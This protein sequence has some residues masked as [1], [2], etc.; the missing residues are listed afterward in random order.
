MRVRPILIVVGNNGGVGLVEVRQRALFPSH[1]AVGLGGDRPAAARE[2]LVLEVLLEDHAG[3]AA[4]DL[5]ARLDRVRAGDVLKRIARHGADGRAVDQHGGNGVARH[6]S[7]REGLALAFLD[8]GAADRVDAAALT[9]SRGDLGVALDVGLDACGLHLDIVDRGD[10]GI[11]LSGRSGVVPAQQEV[12]HAK[13]G[14]KLHKGAV[15]NDIA[16]HG[17]AQRV[18]CIPDGRPCAAAVGGGLDREGEFAALHAVVRIGVVEF[19]VCLLRAAQIDRRGDQALVLLGLACADVGRLGLV[20]VIVAIASPRFAAAGALPALG[21]ELFGLEVLLKEHF[22]RLGDQLEARLDIIV[23]IDV[24][25]RVGRFLADAAAVDAIGQEVEAALRR[26]REAHAAVGR[27]GLHAA[28]RDAAALRGDGVDRVGRFALSGLEG[29][30][31]RMVDADHFKGIVA[32]RAEIDAVDHQR[33]DLVAGIRRDREGLGGALAHERS[34]GRRDRAVLGGRGLHGDIILCAI[35]IDLHAAEA[36]GRATLMRG[37]DEGKADVVLALIGI[38]DHDLGLRIR[39]VGIEAGIMQIPDRLP[40]RAVVGRDI[41]RHIEVRILHAEGVARVEGE[42][43][44]RG[45]G[46]TGEVIGRRIQPFILVDLVALDAREPI[47]VADP[48]LDGLA[49]GLRRPAVGQPLILEVLGIEHHVVGHDHIGVIVEVALGLEI[50]L[51]GVAGVVMHGQ[52]DRLA[53][54]GDVDVLEDGRLARLGLADADGIIDLVVFRVCEHDR[55]DILVVL[56]RDG[57]VVTALRLAD[58]HVDD[59]RSL[60]VDRDRERPRVAQVRGGVLVIDRG[61]RDADGC[62]GVVRQGHIVDIRAVPRV[63]RVAVVGERAGRS[64]LIDAVVIDRF[65]LIVDGLFIVDRAV[66]AGDLVGQRSG[67]TQQTGVD[68]RQGVEEIV[69]V[70]GN[71]VA[72]GKVRDGV[73][74]VVLAEVGVHGLFHGLEQ[75]LVVVGLRVGLLVSD[76]VPPEAGIDDRS[77]R[78]VAVEGKERSAQADAVLILGAVGIG[79]LQN[80]PALDIRTVFKLCKSGLGVGQGDGD[81]DFLLAVRRN[82][83]QTVFDV[84]RIGAGQNHVRLGHKGLALVLLRAVGQHDGRG[85]IVERLVAGVMHRERERIDAGLR[86]VVAQLHLRAIHT[87]DGDI[88]LGLDGGIDVHHAGAL[89]ARRDGDVAVIDDRGRA[90]EQGVDE[91]LALGRV[92]IRVLRLDGLRNDRHAAGNMR[93]GHGRA[94]HQLIGAVAGDCGIDVAAGRGDLGLEGQLGGRAPRGEVAHTRDR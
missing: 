64:N 61:G 12:I 8:I 16:G 49:L 74:V 89:T 86:D 85:V 77:L 28:R 69:I 50:E 30:A 33:S 59:L 26:G 9:R 41:D 72:I 3:L 25:E 40:V 62:L 19:K 36:V 2:A 83:D 46:L 21:R 55:S 68:P 56:D 44:V 20:E 14:R 17:F 15:G 5:E 92:H 54:A 39:P 52:A 47:L 91:V 11:I 57:R 13:L 6:R 75:R 4:R 7:D 65:R 45:R 53:K 84:R 22:G 88:A 35:L 63:D 31:D 24:F 78:P 42:H 34:A 29:R 73:V 23:L 43:H 66:R 67:R 80:R 76:L 1:A 81:R 32:D 70:R 38:G 18:L 90:H 37:I 48:A 79:S 58:A 27:D 71:R 60:G 94:G 82:D 51:L 87:V 10:A 93:R